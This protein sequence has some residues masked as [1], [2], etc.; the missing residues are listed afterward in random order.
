MTRA[1]FY[2]PAD[3]KV[4]WYG[5]GNATVSP[6]KVLWHTTET[7]GGWPGYGNG[8]AAP[9]F[10]YD[11]WKHQWRQHFPI[12]GT[13][14]ALANGSGYSTNRQGVCQIEV[15]CYSDP[16]Y[17]NQYGYGI[18]QFDNQA[19]QD[20]GD[21]SAF[22]RAEWGVPLEK[23]RLPFVVVGKA[24][25]KFTRNT[26]TA[27]SGH[28]GHQHAPD[29][30]HGDP[31]DWDMDRILAAAGG[32]G[33]RPLQPEEDDMP[34]SMDEIKQAIAEVLR[35]EGVSGAG[36]AG[37]MRDRGYYQMSIDANADV[38]RSEGMSGAGDPAYN[39]T[40]QILDA[41]A[42]VQESVD[43]LAPKAKKSP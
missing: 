5:Q 4:Q 12:N 39:G 17:Y 15:S 3:R 14:R 31:G 26:F 13:A 24:Q 29:N 42:Q 18:H 27:F 1:I 34:F 23:T 2:P 43:G 19:Y 7:K 28:C 25:Q 6:T 11:P 8:G 32:S 40:Q 30:N 9:N 37:A 38:A 33:G 21:F 16:R 35:S 20:L 41:V 10:T 22:M 36:D